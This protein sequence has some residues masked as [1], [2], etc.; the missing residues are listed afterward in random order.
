MIELNIVFD[1]IHDLMLKNQFIFDMLQ[2][3]YDHDVNNYHNDILNDFYL[4]QDI[5]PLYDRIWNEDD[6]VYCLALLKTVQNMACGVVFHEY[7]DNDG[8]DNNNLSK[9]INELLK[10]DKQRVISDGC[11]INDLLIV[12]F[13][14]S[15][16]NDINSL[17]LFQKLIERF[18]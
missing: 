11:S 6:I 13:F 17:M 2:S 12:N 9:T 8:I 4:P 18:S 15:N 14:K 5:R 7:N 3:D 1:K 16:I 10:I